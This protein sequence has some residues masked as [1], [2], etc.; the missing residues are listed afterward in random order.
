MNDKKAISLSDVKKLL[1]SGSNSFKLIDIRSPEK[2]SKLHI[3]AAENIPAEELLNKLTSFS[4]DNTIICV[5]NKGHQRSQNAAAFLVSNGF[6]NS[7]YLEGG[8]LGW[9]AE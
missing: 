1:A 7:F 9:F 3:P 8:T 6:E 2:Y 4:K 5:C